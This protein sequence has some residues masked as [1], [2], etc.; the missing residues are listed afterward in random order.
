MNRHLVAGR[1]SCV[2]V[3]LRPTPAP[4]FVEIAGQISARAVAERGTAG[5]FCGKECCA[6]STFSFA[7]KCGG[8]VVR[9]P[10]RPRT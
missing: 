5:E 1:R 3:D 2:C 10:F 9:K 4:G 8:R 6:G 7:A